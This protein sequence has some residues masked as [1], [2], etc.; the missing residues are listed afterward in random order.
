MPVYFETDRLIARSYVL[1]DWPEFFD[2]MSDPEG[3]RWEYADPY[4]EPAARDLL[5][6]MVNDP[7]DPHEGWNEYALVL[8]DSGEY[9][10][11]IGFGFTRRHLQAEIGYKIRRTLWGQG[12]ATEALYAMLGYCFGLGVHRAYAVIEPRNLPS[13]RVAEKAGMRREALLV[14]N[15]WVKGEWQNEYIY[16]MLDREFVSSD[17]MDGAR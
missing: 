7:P 13:V 16:A 15:V 17:D 2:L 10:G 5:T 4:D 8:K 9:I 3:A 14:E 12:L 11:G 1:T 6:R